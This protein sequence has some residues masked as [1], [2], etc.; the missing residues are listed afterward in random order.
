V[1][2]F[3]V[4]AV[5]VVGVAAAA[6][7]ASRVWVMSLSFVAGLRR[8]VEWRVVIPDPSAYPTPQRTFGRRPGQQQVNV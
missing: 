7:A 1:N 4:T 3:G 2:R 6:D 8:R 5:V